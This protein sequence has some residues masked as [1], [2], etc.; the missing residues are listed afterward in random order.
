MALL[1]S[2]EMGRTALDAVALS[3]IRTLRVL[4]VEDSPL[5]SQ[6]ISDL[7]EE[8][9][10]VRLVG[11]VRDE[12]AAMEL[13]EDEPVDALILDLRLREGTGFGVLKRLGGTLAEGPPL[14]IIFTNYDLPE[15]RRK[16]ASLGVAHFLDKSRDFDVLIRLLRDASDLDV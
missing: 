6:R 12:Q 15:Y 1:S 7:I 9:P 3:S 13:I 2:H 8:L 4:L 5:V 11:T 14:K 16:A 10:S